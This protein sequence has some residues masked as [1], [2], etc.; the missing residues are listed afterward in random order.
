MKRSN[1]RYG[2][3]ARITLLPE[4]INFIPYDCAIYN[5]KTTTRLCIESI[6]LERVSFLSRI[7]TYGVRNSACNSTLLWYCVASAYK[8]LARTPCTALEISQFAVRGMSLY[9]ICGVSCVFSAGWHHL[10]QHQLC[11]LTVGAVFIRIPMF[12]FRFRSAIPANGSP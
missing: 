11:I 8:P 3:P 2:S 10:R 7:L 12:P 1:L 5:Q 9:N 6:Q 4:Q